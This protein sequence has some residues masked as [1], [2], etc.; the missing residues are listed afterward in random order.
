MTRRVSQFLLLT[1]SVLAVGVPI[2]FAQ[3][4][5][6]SSAAPPRRQITATRAST[7]PRIDGVLDDEAWQLATPEGDFIQAEPYEGKASTERTEVRLLYDAENLYIGVYCH[8]ATPRGVRVNSLKEDFDPIDADYFQVILDTYRDQRSGFLFTTNP[9]GAK[10]DAQVSDEG[11]TVNPDWDGIWNVRAVITDDGWTAELVIPF[12][13]LSFD[14]ARSEQVWG[15]NLSRKIRRKNEIA[16]WSPIPRRYDINRL[17]LAG[18]L[19]GLEAVQ[20]GRNLRVKPFVVADVQS[21]AKKGGAELLPNAG[22]DVKYSVTPSLTLDLTGN[23]DFSQV[24]VDEQQINITRFPVIFPEKR[25]FFLENAGIFQFGDVPGERGP[26]RSKETQLF[27]SRRIGL[28]PDGHAREG[29][30]IDILGGARLSGRLGRYTLGVLSLQT[31]T[32]NDDPATAVDESLPSTNFTVARV[33]RDVLANSDIGAIIVNREASGGKDYNRAMGVDGNFR[34]FQNLAINGYVGQTKADGMSCDP[35]CRNWT[36]KLGANWRDNRLRLQAVWANVEENFTPDVGLKGLPSGRQS[37]ESLRATAEVH[38]RPPTNP[39]I[40]EVNPHPR[41]FFILDPTNRMVYREGHFSPSEI[42]FHNGS[43][44]EVS[45]NPRFE[46]LDQSF[47]IPGSPGVVVP[48]GEYRY[49]YWQFEV[50]SDQSRQ[51]FAT[52]DIQRGTYYTGESSIVNLTGTLRPGYRWSAQAT[53]VNSH[54][55]IQGADYTSRVV[56]TRLTY[57]INTRMFLNALIQYN[58]SRQQVTSNVRFD[59]IHRPLSDL[60]LVFNEAR[61]VSGA[62]LNDRAFTIKYTHMLSF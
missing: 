18:E 59:F 21:L 16:F 61:D 55:Q 58:S 5:P 38:L 47:T 57:S 7:P 24:E 3:H 31:K 36:Q 10:H 1:L 34:F 23:T 26:D 52:V 25:E 53:L 51:L 28:F 37:G 48:P 33:K 60:F 29:E 44:V 32:V 30:P 13:S 45:Y 40:R 22:L 11:R 54:V 20:R 2:A 41:I 46:I 6:A 35:S 42:F 19:L 8:D 49:G 50:E 14:G 27:F 4:P 15:I 39:V 9:H 43:R 12:K 56:R 62:G 17:S